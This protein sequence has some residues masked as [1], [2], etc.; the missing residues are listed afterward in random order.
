MRNTSVPPVLVGGRPD[1]ARDHCGRGRP[2]YQ[3][4]QDGRVPADFS[5]SLR[6]LRQVPLD[7]LLWRDGLG[8]VA[9]ADEGAE[10]VIGRKGGK[11]E[12]VWRIF[13]TD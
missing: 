11:E 12:R 9:G 6:L 8:L 1:R 7:E 10:M 3:H 13:V 4:R 2:Q 5:A